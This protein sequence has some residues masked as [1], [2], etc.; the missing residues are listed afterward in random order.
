MLEFN[1]EFLLGFVFI[2]VLF[3]LLFKVFLNS[4]LCLTQGMEGVGAYVQ[5][6]TV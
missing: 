2:C 5:E 6:T 3:C 1:M 4:C